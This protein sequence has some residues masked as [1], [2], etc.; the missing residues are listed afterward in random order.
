[1]TPK[2]HYLE[3]YPQQILETGPLNVTWTARFES[4]HREFV[5][6]CESSKNFVNVLK[7][8]SWNSQKKLA[9]R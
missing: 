2:Y 3:H 9:S 5:N 1:M 8:L 6:W 7:T 4:K